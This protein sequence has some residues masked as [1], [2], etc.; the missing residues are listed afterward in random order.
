MEM[1]TDIYLLA[2]FGMYVLLVWTCSNDDLPPERIKSE[3]VFSVLHVLLRLCAHV[4][5][6]NE[7][8]F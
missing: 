4:I 1:E 7:Y 8:D 5:C 2:L 3:G 6:L